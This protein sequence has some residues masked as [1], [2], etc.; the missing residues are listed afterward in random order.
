MRI[1]SKTQEPQKN[2]PLQKTVKQIKK[3]Y[4]KMFWQTIY[5][6]VRIN[7]YCKTKKNSLGL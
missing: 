4:K 6:L 7:T 1:V 5:P 2:I 3:H